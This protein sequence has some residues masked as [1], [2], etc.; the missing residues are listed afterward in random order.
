VFDNNSLG[1]VVWWDDA[2]KLLDVLLDVGQMQLSIAPGSVVADPERVRA[3]G[4]GAAGSGAC[5]GGGSG[6]SAT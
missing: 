1:T 6:G 4:G 3:R 5:G 2:A